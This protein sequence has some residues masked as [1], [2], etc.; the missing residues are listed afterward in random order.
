MKEKI[1]KE[2]IEK[3]LKKEDIKNI[4]II[5]F[6]SRARKDYKKG[7]DWDLLIVVDKELEREERLKI[8]HLIRKELAEK[9]I[10]CD[11]LIKSEKEVEKRKNVIGSVIKIALKEGIVL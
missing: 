5:L 2:T 6:G 8:A 9:F 3:I 4:K 10:P 11:I 7:S 1:I